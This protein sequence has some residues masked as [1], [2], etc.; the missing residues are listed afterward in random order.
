MTTT[1]SPRTDPRNARIRSRRFTGAATSVGAFLAARPPWTPPTG[2]P[3][4]CT[5]THVNVRAAGPDRPVHRL[6]VVESARN[7]YT[8]CGSGPIAKVEAVLTADAPTCQRP[9]CQPDGAS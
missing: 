4:A 6:R 2:Q 9:A 8:R 7:Y 1:P 5:R 3:D